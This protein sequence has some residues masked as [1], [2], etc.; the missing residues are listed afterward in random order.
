MGVE[1]SVHVRY[2]VGVDGRA[3][4]GSI[5]ALLS[6]NTAFEA[7]A[8]NAIAGAHFRPVRRKDRVV[9]Q[10]VEQIVRFTVQR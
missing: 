2:I 5:Q 9:R 4:P 3:D 10:L 6:T 8:V 1:G 7:P